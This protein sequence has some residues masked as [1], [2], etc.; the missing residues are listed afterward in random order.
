MITRKK[1]LR[2]I[3]VK[4]EP[5]MKIGKLPSRVKKVTGKPDRGDKTKMSE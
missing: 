4:C 1:D 2:I 3:R 5:N